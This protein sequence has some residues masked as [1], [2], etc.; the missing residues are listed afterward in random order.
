MRI[1]IF[2][3]MILR[4]KIFFILL[5]AI[6][7]S[8][9]AYAQMAAKIAPGKMQTCVV[10]KGDTLITVRL[11]EVYCFPKRTFRSQKEVKLYWRDVH[12]VKKTLPLATLILGLS[13]ATYD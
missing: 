2:V 12:D 1:L 8:A 9:S 11:R 4:K 5:L 10:E 3:K 13:L 6:I 7:G